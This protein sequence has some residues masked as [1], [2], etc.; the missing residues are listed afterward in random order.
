M[1]ENNNKEGVDFHQSE[2]DGPV[3]ENPEDK[4]TLAEKVKGMLLFSSALVLY[5]FSSLCI[6]VAM[7]T[8]GMSAQEVLYYVSLVVLL[9]FYF[10]SSS[11]K[12]D[13]L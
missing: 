8:Y 13:I 3:E 4:L 9:C 11:N 2:K 1:S 10:S 7:N 6:K 5:S 12:V